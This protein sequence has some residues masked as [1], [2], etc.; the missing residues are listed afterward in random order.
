VPPS[1]PPSPPP[2]KTSEEEFKEFLEEFRR[3]SRRVYWDN[4]EKQVNTVDDLYRMAVFGY[5]Y[6]I[7]TRSLFQI[8]EPLRELKELIGMTEA[9]QMILDIV[10]YYLQDMDGDHRDLMHTVIVGPPGTGKTTLGRIL[11]KLYAGMGFLSKPDKFTIVKRTDLVG[12]YLGHTAQ[13]TKKKIEECLGGVFFIDECYSLAPRDSSKDSFAKEAIDGINE[14]LT[15]H[16][17]DLV[18]M[19]AGYE[20]ELNNTFFAMNSGLKRRFPWK[21]VLGDYSADDLLA[22]YKK[23][24]REQEWALD[25]GAL[26]PEFFRTNKDLFKHF[27]GDVETFVA[28]CKIASGRRTF[29]QPPSAQRIINDKDIAAALEMHKNVMSAK[30][31]DVPPTSM[32]L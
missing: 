20:D 31:K 10:M 28:K 5:N 2:E 19:I 8:I 29:G 1:S 13:L 15:E 3:T 22:I 17:G 12:K 30:E 4:I 32:Y 25:D 14:A 11:G 7:E 9:K 26:T 27:G 21:I 24:L 23:M 18:C 6:Y 16:K